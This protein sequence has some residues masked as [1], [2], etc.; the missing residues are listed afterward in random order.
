[1]PMDAG[2]QSKNAE[3]C[4][5][6]LYPHISKEW[7]PTKN[8]K[9][10]PQDVTKGC[11]KKVWWLCP[12]GHS[13]VNNIVTRV[14]QRQ[15]CPYCYGKRVYEDNS[16]ATLLPNLAN[17]WHPTKNGKLTPHD[18]TKSSHKKI[19]QVCPNGHEYESVCSSRS[20]NIGCPY[21]DGKKACK[22]N[23]LSNIFPDIAKE[24]HPI[25]NGEFTPDK[26][27]KKSNTKVWWL[28]PKGHEYLT[29]PKSRTSGKNCP[30]CEGNKVC[31]ENCL[32]N[33]Y[34]GIA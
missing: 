29:P 22:E 28:C 33:L 17:E 8:H 21:C 25:K 13:Y 12:K 7:N 34:S 19:L 2:L 30:Y 4:L 9:L 31:A 10:R 3:N 20:K 1:M 6:A 24:W 32:A 23:S 11:G 27:T 15:S 5:A 14:T 26:I 16:V 18:V